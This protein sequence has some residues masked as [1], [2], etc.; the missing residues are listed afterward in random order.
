MNRI[1]YS[2]LLAIL[3]TLNLTAVATASPTF[4]P[5]QA[6]GVTADIEVLSPLNITDPLLIGK[7]ISIYLPGCCLLAVVDVKSLEDQGVDIGLVDVLFTPDANWWGAEVV[8]YIDLNT[9]T[10]G[11][12]NN[13]ETGVNYAIIRSSTDPN[14]VLLAIDLST[15]DLSNVVVHREAF[16]DIVVMNLYGI[17]LWL[18]VRDYNPPSPPDSALSVNRFA[19]IQPPVIDWDEYI[20]V[21]YFIGNTEADKAKYGTKVNITIRLPDEIKYLLNIT[22]GAPELTFENVTV[23]NVT[24]FN[25]DN[26]ADRDL[27]Y[28]NLFLVPQDNDYLELVDWDISADGTVLNITGYVRDFAPLA[29]HEDASSEPKAF[30]GF[31]VYLEFNRTADVGYGLNLSELPPCPNVVD[32]D[33]ISF[34]FSTTGS[35]STVYVEVWTSLEVVGNYTDVAFDPSDLNPGDVVRFK[36]HNLPVPYN[37]TLYQVV[38]TTSYT[39]I[40]STTFSYVGTESTPA[41]GIVVYDVT[42]PD[43]E[44]GGLTA[45]VTFVFRRVGY[46]IHVSEHPS[47]YPVTVVVKPYADI[48]VLLNDPSYIVAQD[49]VIYRQ[50]VHWSQSDYTAAPGDY[51]LVKGYGFITEGGLDVLINETITLKKL[52]ERN[53]SSDPGLEPGRAILVVK[54]NVTENGVICPCRDNRLTVVGTLYNSTNRYTTDE[55]LTIDFRPDLWKILVNPDLLYDPVAQTVYVTQE[56]LSLFDVYYDLVDDPVAPGGDKFVEDTL[57][58]E[59]RL[60]VIGVNASSV[61]LLFDNTYPHFLNFTWNNVSLQCG[62]AYVDYTGATIPFYPMGTY[63]LVVLN[64]TTVLV[65]EAINGSDVFEVHPNLDIDVLPDDDTSGR[66]CCNVTFNVVGGLPDDVLTFH[67]NAVIEITTDEFGGPTVWRTEAI[68]VDVATNTY[69]I[70]NTTIYGTVFYDSTELQNDVKSYMD[71]HSFSGEGDISFTIDYSGEL[72]YF[73]NDTLVI[74]YVY[75]GTNTEREFT[76]EVTGTV[77]Y[78]EV[79]DEIDWTVSVKVPRTRVV[80]SVPET[81]LPGDN[82]T[83]QIFVHETAV[84]HDQVTPEKLWELMYPYWISVR[85]VDVSASTS[86]SWVALYGGWLR[87]DSGTTEVELPNGKVAKLVRVL[88]DVDGDGVDEVVFLVVIPAPITTYDV[89]LRVDVNITLAYENTG[90]PTF[91]DLVDD[92]CTFEANYTGARLWAT[93]YTHVLY[94]GDHHLTTVLGLLEA[95]LDYIKDDTVYIRGKVDDVWTFITVDLMDFLEAMNNSIITKIDG[96]TATILTT[97]G[98]INVSLTDLMTTLAGEI[99]FKI[100]E[101]TATIIAKLE[102]VNATLY[103]KIDESTDFLASLVGDLFT[104]LDELEAN[105][106]YTILAVN[107]SVVGHIDVVA[108]DLRYDILLRIDE[109]EETLSDLIT[110]KADEIEYLIN[111]AN[112]T[113]VAKIGESTLTITDAVDSAKADLEV[114]IDGQTA[115]IRSD[116]AAVKTD[117][118]SIIDL[119]NALQTSVS[120]LSV[121]LVQVNDTLYALVLSVG[122]DVKATIIGKADDILGFLNEFKTATETSFSNVLS[123]IDELGTDVEAAKAEVLANLSSVYSD[124]SSKLD[125]L[126]SAISDAS[127]SIEDKITS[128]KNELSTKVETLAGDLKSTV[129]EKTDAVNSNVTTFSLTLLILV[130]VL[131]GLVGYSLIVAR[132]AR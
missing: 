109:A 110:V 18:R 48:F 73:T 31:E 38:F 108:D 49:G 32:N 128:A 68:S 121:K 53:S 106:V 21:E 8:K 44:W 107:E 27:L 43:G 39:T 93:H 125:D 9:T 16:G 127:T 118:E 63:T 23:F 85:L 111:E 126:S 113:I 33:T 97:L 74:W 7:D 66:R 28:S 71:G 88:E 3:L 94:G 5:A 132:R 36:L 86:G 42:L 64:G 76:L 57:D 90:T 11:W 26:P 50:F 65:P 30:Y 12:I 95:K 24:M 83:I 78:F 112:I 115:T 2:V 47:C 98:E 122:D 35:T 67:G 69:G 124:L 104:R 52:L 81:V 40:V 56:R 34:V 123:A 59:F 45:Y 120:D 105:V 91:L 70:G 129:E 100:D 4:A 54:V 119:V 116:I 99:E 60:E 87:F 96:S 61:E 79:T 131:I 22:G 6:P 82:I 14:I 37:D 130:I 10:D 58:E 80:V 13:P 103:L 29:V 15:I 55:N 117:T 89:T 20:T 17:P 25:L 75:W 62:Y 102:D 72:D 1:I 92:E 114:Y 46:E 19:V 41:E 77:H 84:S 51:I 101:S